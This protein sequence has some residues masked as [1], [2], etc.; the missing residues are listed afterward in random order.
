MTVTVCKTSFFSIDDIAVM[1]KTNNQNIKK[2]PCVWL[3]HGSGG[4]SSNEDLWINHAFKLDYTVIIVDS[5]SNRGIYKQNWESMEEF[6]VDPE[7]RAKDQI[8]TYEYLLNKQK[9]IPFADITNSKAVGFS[10]GGTAAL[11]LQQN[12]NPNYWNNSYC[13]YPGL[14]PTVLPQEIYQ[15]RNH[16]VHIFVGELDNWTP[17][18]YDLDYQKLTNCKITIWPETHHSFSKPGID[19]WHKNTL[20]YKKERGVYCK[21]NEEATQKTIEVVFNE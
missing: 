14:K 6:R 19:T 1:I 15:I 12:D 21:Y 13:L 17:A 20:N 10:D 2:Q 9:I 8:K 7:Q 11:W 18:F 3:I 4:I 16:N 5:Y